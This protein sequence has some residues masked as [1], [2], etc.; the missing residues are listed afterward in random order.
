[1][2]RDTWKAVYGKVVVITGASSGAGRAIAIE[3][4]RNGAKLVLAARRRE[5]LEEVAIECASLGGKAWVVPTDTREAKDMQNLAEEAMQFGGRIDVWINN[6]GVLAAGTFDDIPSEV[7]ENV[8]RTNLL[9]YIHGAQAVLPIFKEQG[10]G[11]LIN[12]ISVGGWFPTP[13]M[14]AYSASKFGLRG[15]FESLKGELNQY[16][17]IH[18]CDLYPGFLDTPGIQHAANFTGKELKPAPPVYDP[19]K[20]A[21]AVISIVKDPRSKV[22]IGVSSAFLRFAYQHFPALSR[23]ITAAVIRTYLKGAGP[24]ETTSGNI[25]HTVDYGTGIDG[26]WRN[27]SLKPA[28]RIRALLFAG[29][30]I[31]LMVMGKKGG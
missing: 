11:M 25:M 4:A 14:A 7:N 31:G 21:R 13:Y 28:P 3:F 8:I 6:A 10:K 9:G 27:V 2:G 1:M 26:G 29:L 17:N 18:V 22:T 24:T 20:V 5:A 16:P 23:N 15:F 19:R 12:N 30:A